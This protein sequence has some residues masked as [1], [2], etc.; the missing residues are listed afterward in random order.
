LLCHEV[1]AEEMGPHLAT[2]ARSVEASVCRVSATFLGTGFLVDSRHVVTAL[3]IVSGAPKIRIRCST[4][5]PSTGEIPARIVRVLKESDL[6]LLQIDQPAAEHP[7]SI[8]TAAPTP[9]QQLL[10][11]GYSL[12]APQVQPRPI[13]AALI[14]TRL[15]E[16][17]NDNTQYEV[18]RAGINIDARVVHLDGALVPGLSGAP[19]VNMD[20]HVVAI[21]D[22]GLLNGAA[23]IS[24]AMPGE[25]IRALMV[26]AEP[27]G[28][29]QAASRVLFGAEMETS[30][31][32]EIVAG[33]VRLVQTRSARLSEIAATADDARLLN[34]LIA[35]IRAMRPSLDPS[36]LTFD[37]LQDAASAATV[38]LPHAFD[39][40]VGSHSILVSASQGRLHML[41]DVQKAPSAVDSAV[42]ETSVAIEQRAFPATQQSQ[43]V[44]DPAWTYPMKYRRDDGVDF[45]RKSFVRLD[46]G[47]QIGY[48][49]ETL[50]AKNNVVVGAFAQSGVNS[51][52][53]IGDPQLAEDWLK[54]LIA[55][56]LTSFSR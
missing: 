54:I 25:R 16:I 14:R 52:D 53:F 17:L 10:A 9:G 31:D 40:Q 18:R 32:R 7:L 35:P 6:A 43:W 49:F 24:W 21:G 44:L 41:V 3:H 11:L 28:T 55:T 8:E 29:L 50:A 30:S 56:H 27:V 51:M 1:S 48:T 37:I 5:K 26:S 33:P 13:K 38:V 23:S 39:T 47:K 19:V 15:S 2:V 42:Q 4:S 46:L 22:G 34:M 20:G 12:G 36:E 45:T